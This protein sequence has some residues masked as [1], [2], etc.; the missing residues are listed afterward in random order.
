[1]PSG[2]DAFDATGA[3]APA[4]PDTPAY[5][6]ASFDRAPAELAVPRPP[7]LPPSYAPPGAF[8]RWAAAWQPVEDPTC[9]AVDAA[10]QSNCSDVLPYMCL[11]NLQCASDLA[12][13]KARGVT[14]VLTLTKRV[15][16]D[17]VRE[18]MNCMQIVIKDTPGAQIHEVW[19]AACAHV[20]AAKAAGGKVLIHCRAG[21]SRGSCCCMAYLMT[22]G[23][24]TLREAYAHVKQCRPI[25]HP[26]KGFVEQL[27]Q[28]EVRLRGALQG[29][30]A[31]DELPFTMWERAEHIGLN[32]PIPNL[33]LARRTERA[34][35]AAYRERYG[36]ANPYLTMDAGLGGK[37]DLHTVELYWVGDMEWIDRTLVDVLY[38]RRPPNSSYQSRRARRSTAASADPGE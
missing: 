7:V 23:G 9:I 11:G 26:N 5:T 17:D 13:L 31:H 4:T 18:A 36:R 12:G 27:R 29:D 2:G 10:V 35:A 8:R 6:P 32:D 34:V 21:V 25:A 16:P 15:L 24:M 20:L 30:V 19:H 33:D 22:H 38:T 28:L 1:M 37:M 14:H 3:A